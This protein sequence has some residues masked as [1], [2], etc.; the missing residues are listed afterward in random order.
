[1]RSLLRFLLVLFVCGAVYAQEACWLC[2]STVNT[3][4][5]HYRTGDKSVCSKCAST[6]PRCALCR[7]PGGKPYRDG[8]AICSECLSTG[9]FD[10]GK[11]KPMAG[12]AL[13]FLQDTLGKQYIADL[14]PIQLV[15][16]DEMQTKMN[17]GGRAVAVLAFYRP[18]NPEMVYVLTGETELETMHHL[19]HEL[20]HAWQSRACVQQD[21]ALK[22]GFASWVQ[23][24]YLL[25]RGAQDEAE[26]VLHH[27]DP[28][29]GPPCQQLLKRS[30]ALGRAAFLAKVQKAA[31]LS[32]V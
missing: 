28:D 6:T 23:Y 3:K 25:S 10:P 5:F 4:T 2:H 24:Q 7:N 29:Y 17:E 31:K 15:D 32:D 20:T 13:Q 22:E 11:V 18:Y 14:P 19:V 16:L 26:H 9:T 21:R 12:K 1:M 27:S 8:R 30:Q